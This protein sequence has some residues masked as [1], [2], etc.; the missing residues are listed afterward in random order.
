MLG[1]FFGNSVHEHLVSVRRQNTEHQGSEG[2][3]HDH[4]KLAEVDYQ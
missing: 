4:E 3:I 2:E 1:F